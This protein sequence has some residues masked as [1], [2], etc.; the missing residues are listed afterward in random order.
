MSSF[1]TTPEPARHK[2]SLVNARFSGHRL[3]G[4]LALVG[5]NFLGNSWVR[6]GCARWAPLIVSAADHSRPIPHLRL[7]RIQPVRHP[8]LAVHRCRGGEV[9]LR[10]LALARG[11]IEL[12]ETEVAVR[13]EGAHAARLG[14]GERLAVIAFGAFFIDTIGMGRDVAE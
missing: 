6:S 7:R 5:C 3:W 14:Q 12:A 2:E 4:S 8:H 11:P 1:K 13:D 9:L 10:L